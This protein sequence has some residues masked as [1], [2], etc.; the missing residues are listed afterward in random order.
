MGTGG[1][2]CVYYKAEFQDY[3]DGIFQSASIRVDA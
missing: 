2:D 1:R 3:L